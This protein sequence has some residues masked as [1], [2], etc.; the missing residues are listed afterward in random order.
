MKKQICKFRKSK[1][2]HLIKKKNLKCYTFLYLQYTGLIFSYYVLIYK[3][4]FIV[5][6]L[7]RLSGGEP[8]LHFPALVHYPMYD[9]K[10]E[11]QF[12]P[13]KTISMLGSLF[14][15][16]YGSLFSEYLFRSGSLSPEKDVLGCVV[17][18]DSARVILPSDTSF[19]ISC[20]TL[21][22]QQQNNFNK[23]QKSL[24]NTNITTTNNDLL[25][26]NTSGK[27]DSLIC[28]ENTSLHLNAQNDYSS[29]IIR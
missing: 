23:Q 1:R 15:C 10:E 27:N 11:K 8:L 25:S 7:L 13:F 20:D 6:L 5:G 17:N 4:N 22:M 3:I 24:F 14:C 16:V 9:L 18:I 19:N 12:F 29:M 26:L 28:N 21:A 2:N